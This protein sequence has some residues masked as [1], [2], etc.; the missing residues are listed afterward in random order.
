MPSL[1][2]SQT[3]QIEE[4]PQDSL[5]QAVT[6]GQYNLVKGQPVNVINP[7]GQLVSLPAEQVPEAL[8]SNFKFPTQSDITSYTNQQKYETPTEEAKTFG[9]GVASGATFGASREAENYIL[10]NRAEQKARQETNPGLST[11]GELTGAVGSAVLAPELSPVG[12]VSHLGQGVTEAASSM[13]ANPETASHVAKILSSMGS[14]ALGSAVEGTVYGLGNS[15]SEHAL[16]DA[17]FNAENIMHNVGYGALFGGALGSALGLGEGAYEGAFGKEA[18]SAALKDSIMENAAAHP[19]NPTM[20]IPTSMEDIAKRVELGKGLGF[21]EELPQKQRLLDAEKILAGD[22]QFPAHALQTQSLESPFVRDYY[23]TFLEGGT[24]DAQNMQ[25]YESFQKKEG[26][27][28]INKYVQDISPGSTVSDDAVEGGNKLIK[29]FSDQ[30]EDEKAALK[31][32]FKEFDNKA[33]SAVKDPEMIVNKINEAVPEANQYIYKTDS[34]YGI[35]KYRSSMPLSKETY[36]AL[37]DLL[38]QLNDPDLTIGGLRNI[39]E[40]MRDKVN[41][42]TSPRTSNEI[43]SL[44]KSLMDIIQDEVQ[45][46]SPDLQVRDAFRKYAINEDNRKTMEKIFGGSISDKATFAKEIKPEDVLSKLFSNTVAVKAAKDILG[47][48][49]NSAAADYLAQNV[50]KFTD[51]AKNGFSSNR[52]ASFLKA[53]APELEEGLS[54]RPEQLQKL[55][56]ITDKM[57]ILP[58]SP[59]VNPSGTAKTSL[60]QKMQGLGGYLT[61]HGLMSLP[62]EALQAVGKHIEGFKQTR[63]LNDILAGKGKFGETAQVSD[64][65]MQYGALAKIERMAQETGRKLNRYSNAIFNTESPVR[66]IVAEKLTPEDQQKKFQKISTKLKD[67]TQNFSTGADALEASTKSL[68]EVAPMISSSLNIAAGRATQFLASKLPAQDQP[69]PFEKPFQPSPS[70]LAKFNRYYQTVENPLSVLQHVKNGT[71]SKEHMETLESVYPKLYA[72]MQ[73]SVMDK[74]TTKL[75]KD[76]GSVPYS[77]KLMLSMFTG[78]DLSNS[79]KQQN[80]SSAQQAFAMQDKPQQN[81]QQPNASKA[82]A[83]SKITKSNQLLTETQ[84]VENKA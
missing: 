19:E 22:S 55:Q 40:S 51:S 31:P 26:T 34:G 54:Q 52:F 49:F 27:K 84:K 81:Q 74:I 78:Q 77:T 38:G 42:L 76:P 44:R 75:T 57:R 66:G 28:L 61:P 69:S 67:M 32:V 73:N 68:N 64:K 36:G 39:R 41:F 1:V 3:N 30:Y 58:D 79:L 82:H 46:A 43:S 20:S 60:L 62:G 83:Y 48:K 33:V 7:D 18:K 59:S 9:E 29:D 65:Q 8:N 63:T 45:K 4:V 14:K 16:G 23:K 53:K 12:A 25:A 21:S 71:L 80:I 2:N 56:A 35:Q 72:E 50:N 47:D 70:E 6:S 37:K 13:L 10:K 15:V 24:N 11:A 5:H 17:D